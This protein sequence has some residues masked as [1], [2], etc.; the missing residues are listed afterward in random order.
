MLKTSH[1]F[2]RFFYLMQI[3]FVIFEVQLIIFFTDEIIRRK[4]SYNYWRE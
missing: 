3:V 4:N 1:F 2:V